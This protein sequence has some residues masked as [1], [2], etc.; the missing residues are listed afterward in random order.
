DIVNIT[1]S[2]IYDGSTSGTTTV[3]SGAIAGTSV[4]TLP[5]ATDTLIG[6]ATTDTFTNKTFDANGTG[7]SLSNVDVADLANGTDGELI[8]WSATAVP[9]TV[10]TG[11]A[12]HVLT[13]NG[14]GTAPTF[15]AAAGG[16][17]HVITTGSNA[18]V[19]TPANIG[20][21]YVDTNNNTH[22]F[23]HGTSASSDWRQ[24]V[25]ESDF[26][27]SLGFM[28]KKTDSFP[29]TYEQRSFSNDDGGIGISNQDG[30][31]GAPVWNLTFA[32]LTTD[33]VDPAADFIAFSDTS[34]SGAANKSTVE[35]VFTEAAGWVLVSSATASDDATIDFTG[36]D[37]TYV[38]Y[39]LVV[40]TMVSA[41]NN[42]TLFL[43]IGTGGTP[44]YQSGASDYK[45]TIYE[46]VDAS[47]VFLNDVADS[48]IQLTTTNIA[49]NVAGEH[50]DL[51]VN[52]ARP[53]QTTNHHSVYWTLSGR[54]SAGG[55]ALFATGSGTYLSTTAVTAVR[56]LLSSG[57][58][59]SGDFRLYGLRA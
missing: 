26:G 51:E 43:R 5:V 34:E 58:V 33:T 29:A 52:I 7:N 18:P 3:L 41:N 10:A 8:T 22:W 39:K 46:L 55:R 47:Q 23:A 1:T 36:L 32:N 56:L 24:V 6:K 38:S 15:Q 11:T 42:E 59:T 17:D 28:V 16:G 54:D 50:M 12:T 57:N 53:S 48:E 2:T 44:T 25:Q 49:G 27:S 37:S 20:D 40:T 14:A 19:S 45:W 21:H 4:L 13:S 9:T 35:D 30:I 31:A